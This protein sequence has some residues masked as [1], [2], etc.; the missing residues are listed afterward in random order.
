MHCYYICSFFRYFLK[1]KFI[2]LMSWNVNRLNHIYM[3]N[4]YA[5]YRRIRQLSTFSEI[6]NGVRTFFAYGAFAERGKVKRNGV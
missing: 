5:T 4:E 6:V 3:N 2:E 1:L